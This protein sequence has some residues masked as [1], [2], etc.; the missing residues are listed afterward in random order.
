MLGS[1]L[2]AVVALH[3]RVC[4]NMPSELQIPFAR[5][6]KSKGDKGTVT[7]GC[8]YDVRNWTQ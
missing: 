4:R 7:V 6:S 5:R 2:N 1:S 8:I 3:R